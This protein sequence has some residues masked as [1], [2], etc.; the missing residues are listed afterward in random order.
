MYLLLIE[1]ERY[2]GAYPLEFPPVLLVQKFDLLG[3]GSLLD[4]L[5]GSI[6]ITFQ[7]G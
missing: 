5:R 1:F 7:N 3:P 6:L 4:H 2:L